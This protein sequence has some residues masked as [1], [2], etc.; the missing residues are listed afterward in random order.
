MN[1]K[2]AI[3]ALVLSLAPTHASALPPPTEI[4]IVAKEDYEKKKQEREK[5]QKIARE[6]KQENKTL[7]NLIKTFYV[8][9]WELFVEQGVSKS[10][11]IT[12]GLELDFVIK[13]SRFNLDLMKKEKKNVRIMNLKLLAFEL[14]DEKQSIDIN[15]GLHL[16]ENYL[17]IK[18]PMHILMD[19]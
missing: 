17:N 16:V 6:L 2:S 19:Y 14:K 18:N 11:D 1:I 13:P 12:R 15:S 10:D 4:K 3:C 7:V 5:L 8:P 9:H